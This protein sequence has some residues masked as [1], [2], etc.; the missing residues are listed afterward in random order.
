[1][2]R[3]FKVGDRVEV[4]LGTGYPRRRGAVAAVLEGRED[5]YAVVVEE[6]R[7]VCFQSEMRLIDA[8]EALG[9]LVP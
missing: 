1:M 3:V 8:I 9:E 6:G 2:S 4:D 7:L 5:P